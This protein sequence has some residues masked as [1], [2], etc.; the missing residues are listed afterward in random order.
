M[1]TRAA[2]LAWSGGCHRRPPEA[3]KRSRGYND[4][5]LAV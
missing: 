1:A 4:G 3:G 2:L 5:S